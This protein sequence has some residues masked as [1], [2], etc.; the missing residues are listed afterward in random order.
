MIELQIIIGIWP[1][2]VNFSARFLSLLIE[3]FVNTEHVLKLAARRAKSIAARHCEMRQNGFII[4]IIKGVGY[5]V[6]VSGTM[7][8]KVLNQP[9]HKGERKQ[10]L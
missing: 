5:Y 9:A 6:M 8:L 7:I 4:L 1:K 10:S 3:I 2:H